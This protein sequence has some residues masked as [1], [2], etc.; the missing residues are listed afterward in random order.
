M[1]AQVFFRNIR[2]T[3]VVFC[4]FKIAK[5]DFLCIRSGISSLIAQRL[6]Y[7]QRI[8]SSNIKK[9]SIIIIDGILINI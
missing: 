3:L 4:Y 1:G 5:N 6:A 2:Y 7:V 9:Y 8:G